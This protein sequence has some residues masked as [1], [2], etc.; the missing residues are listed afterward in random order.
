MSQFKILTLTALLG[1][2]GSAFAEEEVVVT[3]DQVPAAVKQAIVTAA[4]GATIK[5]IE[6]ETKDG[7]VT[8]EAEWL[9][10]DGKT[11]VEVTVAADGKVLKTERDAEGDDE[12]DDDKDEKKDEK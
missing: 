8:Y 11:E 5:E 10:A 2:S 3:L 1:L 6:Q 9:D 4:A 12:K 7:V